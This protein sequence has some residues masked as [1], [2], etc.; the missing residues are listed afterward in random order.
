MC[1][2]ADG[3]WVELL[4]RPDSVLLPLD[5]GPSEFEFTKV[6]VASED[7]RGLICQGF[8]DRKKGRQLKREELLR[9]TRGVPL[10]SGTIG[11][12]TAKLTEDGLAVLKIVFDLIY[13][14]GECLVG[15]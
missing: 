5:Q 13:I 6:R 10:G 1:S 7:D 9:D 15:F 3:L 2:L 8:L 11:V 4:P 14:S 12:A